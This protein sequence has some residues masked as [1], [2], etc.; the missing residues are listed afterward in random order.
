MGRCGRA[1]GAVPGSGSN[2]RP[3]SGP[4]RRRA[5]F[6]IDLFEYSRDSSHPAAALRPVNRRLELASQSTMNRSIVRGGCCCILE[7]WE[8]ATHRSQSRDLANSGVL[9]YMHL[10]KIRCVQR[11]RAGRPR[12][13]RGCRCFTRS[14][15]PAPAA[16]TDAAQQQESGAAPLR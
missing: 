3:H 15:R 13:A 6:S 5:S 16:A 9:G 10:L 11:V 14:S 7:S 12:R 4:I 2:C 1:S 8:S